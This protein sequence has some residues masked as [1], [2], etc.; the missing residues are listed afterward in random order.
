MRIA[1]GIGEFRLVYWRFLATSA[2]MRIISFSEC[3][4]LYII[5]AQGTRRSTTRRSGFNGGFSDARWPSRVGGDKFAWAAG[6]K[7]TSIC[8]AIRLGAIVEYA[9]Q[10]ATPN[11][12]LRSNCRSSDERIIV[13][14]RRFLQDR[15]SG[16]L[17]NRARL[18]FHFSPPFARRIALNKFL[19]NSREARKKSRLVSFAA[20]RERLKLSA[21]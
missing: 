9:R 13:P 15:A 3:S 4:K 14:A 16:S 8:G 1:A 17:R 12:N 19:S 7:R 11:W 5:I 10:A 21:I 20:R 18:R 6:P 2:R